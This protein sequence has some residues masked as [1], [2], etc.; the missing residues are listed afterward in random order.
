MKQ[1]VTSAMTLYEDNQSCLDLVKEEERLSDRSKH[2][3]TRFHFVKDY[4]TQ[5]IV[6]CVYCPT[7]EMLADILTKAIPASKFE[8]FRLQ[9]GLHD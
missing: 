6:T 4:I 2:I 5:K 8:K 1:V 3:D 7:D 9:F